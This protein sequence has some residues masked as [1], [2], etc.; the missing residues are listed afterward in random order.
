MSER[1]SIAEILEAYRNGRITKEEIQE[2][3]KQRDQERDGE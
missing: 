1:Y 3:V 2:M